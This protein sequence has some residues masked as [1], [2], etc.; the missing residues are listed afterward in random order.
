MEG[1]DVLEE[2]GQRCR[3]RG[4]AG[5]A[6]DAG[7]REGREADCSEDAEEAGGWEAECAQGAEVES[8][9]ETSKVR[10]LVS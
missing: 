6:V 2:G 7:G 4:E 9:E 1:F 10:R 3:G 5:C 8:G